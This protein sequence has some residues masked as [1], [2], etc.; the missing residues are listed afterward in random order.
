MGTFVD[1]MDDLGNK[2]RILFM[3]S[4]RKRIAFDLLHIQD[5]NRRMVLRSAREVIADYLG[6]ARPSLSRELGRMQDEEIIRIDGREVY[7]LNQKAFDE[8][9][10]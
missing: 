8:L 10:E 4:V 2:V 5:E 6:I 9:S 1:R 7:I 3:A